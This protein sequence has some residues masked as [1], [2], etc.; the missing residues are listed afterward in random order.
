M[1]P[2][3]L[4]L[5]PNGWMPNNPC[6]PVILY[7]RV[8]GGEREALAREFEK[9]F[10]THGWP[11]QWRDTVYDYHHYHSAAHE[12]LGIAAGNAT[13]ALGGPN[14]AKVHVAAGDV[15]V[16]P[17]GTGHCRSEAS[18]DFLVV[19]AYP[20]GQEWDIC[21]EAPSPAQRESLLTLPAPREDPVEGP[22]GLL[23]RIWRAKDL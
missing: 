3:L 19:G 14:C 11:P 1:Q 5:E 18:S 2:E 21:R 20:A 15:L 17:A 16:L 12:A 23:T 22:G 7:R 9:R 6:S 8:A 4:I 10:G 13:L